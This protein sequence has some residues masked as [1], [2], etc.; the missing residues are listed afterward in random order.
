MWQ[1][2]QGK[3]LHWALTLVT[4][5]GVEPITLAEAKAHLRVDFNDD[6]DYITALIT[7]ARMITEERTSRALI[8]QTWDYVLDDFPDKDYIN[9]RKPTLQSV[10]YVNYIDSSG[11]V[12]VM[13]TTDYVVDKDSI[14]G[15]IFLGFAKIWPVVI[16]QPA[17]A[18]RIRMVCGYAPVIGQIVVGENLGSGDGTLKT[19][20][21]SLVPIK[22]SSVTLY[23]DGA[24]TSSYTIDYTAGNIVCTPGVGVVVTI[25]YTE[26]TDYVANVPQPLIHAMKFLISQWYEQREPVILSRSQLLPVP[27]TFDFLIGPYKVVRLQ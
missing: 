9:L 20:R 19:F 21:A 7:A 5:P 15:R 6:D 4:P 25:D 27:M 8:T 1:Q 16:L 23:F 18:V 11:A 2:N 10:T 24:T 26:A 17:S 22:S 12:G 3:S 13:P 14:P